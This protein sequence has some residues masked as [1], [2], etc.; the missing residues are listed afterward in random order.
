MTLP[1]KSITE[2]SFFRWW[3]YAAVASATFITVMEMSAT[4]IVVPTISEYFGADIPSAQW[5]AVSYMLVVSALIMPAGAIAKTLGTRNVWMWGIFIFAIAALITSFSPTFKMVIVGKILMGIGASAL[6]AN[7]MAMTAGAFPDSERGKALGLHMTAVGIG[8]VGGPVFGGV[9]EG[10]W[11][12][13]AIFLAISV[14]SILSWVFSGLVIRNDDESQGSN[15]RMLAKFDWT[16][17]VLSALFLL[18]V[19]LAISFAQEFGWTSPF[20]IAGFVLTVALFVAF[21]FWERRIREPMLPLAMF[22]SVAFSVGSAARFLS[23]VASSAVFFLMPFFLV[24]GLGLDTAVAALY[25]LPSSA[26]MVVMAPLSGWIADKTGTTIPA[27]FGM[28]C[29]TISMYL[30][31][32]ITIDTNPAFVSGIAALSGVGMSIFMAPNT[33]S[34]MGSAGR[35]RYAIV[36]AF[37]N[38][39][40][41][42]AHVVGIAMPT[43]IVVIVMGSLGYDADLSDPEALKDV[44]LRSAYATSMG[45]AFEISTV[46]M[47]VATVCAIGAG[48]S[49]SE[50][51]VKPGTSEN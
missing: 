16:G 35:S 10:L 40:R 12:W 28:V 39:T 44:G 32:L 13:R 2:S 17:T 36:S 8:A 7:G 4:A 43:A 26:C 3:T 49:S 38:L 47:A 20:I 5:L 19:M 24:S 25:L 50:K 22:K 23:F 1:I 51:T 45:R 46:I 14:F 37:L 41:N 34:I 42:A 48:V 9:I 30:F 18:S 21:I 31:S 15:I 29:S 33:S 6:Q 11:D 27:V